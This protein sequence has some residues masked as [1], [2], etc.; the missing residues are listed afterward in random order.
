MEHRI[1]ISEG[2]PCGLAR[3][4]IA[5]GKADRSDKLVMLRAG[6]PVLRGG[7]GW[8]ADRRIQ[9]TATIGP[10]YARWTPF[11]RIAHL[12]RGAKSAS[13]AIPLPAESGN[14]P[15]RGGAR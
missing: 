7:V 6:K 4:L 11:S 2:S 1:E 9:E 12:S 13:L 14:G 15:R 8:Y 10:C 5:E 3:R